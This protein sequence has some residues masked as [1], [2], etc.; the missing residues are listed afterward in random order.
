MK[1]DGKIIR[2]ERNEFLRL[3]REGIEA[4][5]KMANGDENMIVCD[6]ED[7][8]ICDFTNKE[9]EGP[10]IH[11]YISSTG[12]SEWALCEEKLQELLSEGYELELHDSVPNDQIV[13]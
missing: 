2:I 3:R 4:A 9:I 11:V 13:S 12:A 7:E 10:F 5:K 8:I 6:P 1:K